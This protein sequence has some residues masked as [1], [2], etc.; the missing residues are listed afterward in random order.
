MN[1]RFYVKHPAQWPNVEEFSSMTLELADIDFFQ[2][3][4][5]SAPWHW[6]AIVNGVTFNFWP[7]RNRWSIESEKSRYGMREAKKA[8]IDV[9]NTPIEDPLLE[10]D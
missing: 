6:Q 4:P 2:P 8:I 5:V 7:H 9:A 3:A 1:A 10:D